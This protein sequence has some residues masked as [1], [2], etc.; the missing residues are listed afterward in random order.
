MAVTKQPATLLAKKR[1]GN[2][3]PLTLEQHCADTESAALRLFAPH[4]RWGQA[5]RRF[6][7]LTGENEA[8]FL[9]NLRVAALFHDLGKANGDF[10]AAV[11]AAG[12][13]AQS[14]RHEHLSALVLHVPAL[15]AWLAQNPALDHDAV[16][17]AVLSHHL[18]AAE[19]GE[20]AW[21][22]AK[23]API[24]KLFL[25]HVE[26]RAILERVADVAGLGAP[27]DLPAAPWEASGLWAEVLAKGS[28]AARE[29]RRAV[30]SDPAR[31]GLVLALKAAVIAADGAASGLVREGKTFDWIDERANA[32]RVTAEEIAAK[33]I[34]PRTRQI[35]EARR[36]TEPGWEFRFQRFQTGTAEQGPRALVLAACGTGKT[37]AAWKWAEAQA[38]D[39]DLGKVVFLYPTRGTATEGF[40]DYVAWAPE[41]DASLIH[42]A[43]RY[44]LDAI[45]R[46]P[47]EPAARGRDFALSQDDDRLFA[48]G[49]WS[50]RFF[51]ATVDQFLGF[52]EHSYRSVC[53]LP[54]LADAAVIVDEVHSFDK[55]MFDNLVAFLKAFDVPV[56]CMTAT[57]SDDRRRAL[58]DAGLV[59]YP[60]D[61]HRDELPDLAEEEHAPRYRV[62]RVNDVTE[63]RALAVA[64]YKGSKR[65]LWVVNTVRRCQELARSL[66]DELGARVA[67]YHSGFRLNDRQARHREIVAAFQQREVP[68]FAVTTQ[69]CEMSLDLDADTL[70]TEVAPVTALVQRFGR[71]NRK[72]AGKGAE[73]RGQV[74]VYTPAGEGNPYAPY[75]RAEI[76]AA[77]RF[78]DA[79]GE[80]DVSQ[81]WLGEELAR[82]APGEA[83]PDGS[84]RF[85]ASGYYATPGSLRD[86][87]EFNE[88]CVLDR[89]LKDI[90]AR[91]LA[92][93]PW[94]G[95]VVPVAR[96]DVLHNAERPEWLPKW[97]G[98]ADG[99]RYDE[100]FGYQRG[101]AS[102]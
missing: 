66:Q 100:R 51:S 77:G 94:D 71:S 41:A 36:K 8:R 37:L 28:R 61:E 13:Q 43:S 48:L 22:Q 26:V 98:I 55:S 74:L 80:G 86:I 12:F 82:F 89:D 57:L 93:D 2:R 42:G 90:E 75:T 39:R 49:Y 10:Y 44:E 50:R 70:V 47:D 59:V 87:D 45:A 34:A 92:K 62:R 54:V 79:V 101:G 53:L 30:Q 5:W 23:G 84:A 56:L 1:Y 99:D 67:C 88:S 7:K 85:L 9:L 58:E 52:M 18:K 96:R 40:R 6:F 27:P 16:S 31:N 11:T 64:A 91:A 32:P 95:F 83:S 33:I 68:A 24:V 20:R 60:R 78:L 81:A 63:A 65:V 3:P 19:S 72:R 76:E 25:Q 35:E 46:N 15:R 21:C 97:V 17:A 14:V 29:L 38:R 102:T 4:T 69:V 73:F